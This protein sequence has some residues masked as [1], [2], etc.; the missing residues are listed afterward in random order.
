MK[1]TLR[2]GSKVIILIYKFS[3]IIFNMDNSTPTTI[4]NNNY[5]SSEPIKCNLHVKEHDITC[6]TC[7]KTLCSL[8]MCL[9]RHP[10]DHIY[11]SS[12]TTKTFPL[13]NILEYSQVVQT[14]IDDVNNSFIHDITSKISQLQSEKKEQI[15][16]LTSLLNTLKLRYETLNTELVTI[17]NFKYK[18]NNIQ[19]EIISLLR[20]L[21]H[22]EID[23]Q[24][25]QNN[26]D[27]I[28][29]EIKSEKE[30]LYKHKSSL[31][32]NIDIFYPSLNE[33]MLMYEFNDFEKI[34]SDEI[35]LEN[36]YIDSYIFHN[37]FLD[38]FIR[39]YPF[40]NASDDNKEY[41]CVSLCISNPKDNVK[42][43]VHENFTLVNE[44]DSGSNY[45]VENTCYKSKDDF[46]VCKLYLRNSLKANGFITERGSLIVSCTFKEVDIGTWKQ[47]LIEEKIIEKQ[48][49]NT[50][51][52]NITKQTVKAQIN[53]T[54]CLNVLCML[55]FMFMLNRLF[56]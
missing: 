29:K 48:N 40:G 17:K 10:Q 5:F 47:E 42:Y 11:F 33:H 16:L 44:R 37:N 25:I 14:Y 38:W 7:Q 28:A 22:N 41:V 50:I 51:Q 8:C 52:P 34:L 56:I 45:N 2:D 1:Q 32:C 20:K 55:I 49:R 43:K 46:N 26:I 53:K 15:Q 30:L 31:K 54:I 13:K 6:F 3:L 27:N 36:N 9:Q 35:P 4:I 18:F 24:L 21:S 23:Q 39:V 19:E 12:S